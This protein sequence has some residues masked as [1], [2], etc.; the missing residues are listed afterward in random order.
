[1]RHSGRSAWRICDRTGL[2]LLHSRWRRWPELEVEGVLPNRDDVVD[3]RRTWT[4]TGTIEC[5]LWM[6]YRLFAAWS[7]SEPAID[8]SPT[9]SF[10]QTPTCPHRLRASRTSGTPSTPSFCAS[11]FC[12]IMR[13]RLHPTISRRVPL[14]IR[15][16]PC[17]EDRESRSDPPRADL[18]ATLDSDEIR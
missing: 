4:T 14:R 6:V 5:Q 13:E 2:G 8:L 15:L 1:M 18:L 17:P 11:P 10:R 9:S 16:H 12:L 7:V 3:R